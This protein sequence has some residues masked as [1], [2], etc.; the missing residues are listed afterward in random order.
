VKRDGRG[1]GA[2]RATAGRRCL[3]PA[4]AAILAAAAAVAIPAPAA[5]DLPAPRLELRA[6]GWAVAGRGLELTIGQHGAFAGLPLTVNVA[7]DG[8][9][10]DRI[11]TRGTE[12]RY[13]LADPGWTPGIHE[14]AVKCGTE[15][16]RVAFR[17]LPAW[18]PWAAAAALA[19]LA[20]GVGLGSRARRG[21]RL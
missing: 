6:S 13:R 12:T 19:A 4:L 10:I 11:S 2:R 7:V 5:A 17:V 9:S 3:Q 21:R 20:G 1:T 8:R 14:V 15:H 16:E 18:T